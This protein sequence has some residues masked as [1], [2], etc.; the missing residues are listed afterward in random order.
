MTTC[1]GYGVIVWG[2][3]AV[4]VVGC[5]GAP[6]D[7]RQL[8]DDLGGYRVVATEVSNGC[9][10]GV[11]GSRPSFDFDIELSRESTELFWGREASGSLDAKLAFEF[12]A[13][14]RVPIAEPSATSKGCAIGRSDRITGTLRADTGGEVVGFSGRMSHAF[15]PVADTSCSLDDQIAAGLPRL[16]CEMAYELEAERTRAP[17]SEPE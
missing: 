3:L 4:G 1:S 8:G 17:S 15:E 16:P 5:S 13:L 6:A 7:G 10:A 12:R 2:A 11:L 14:V 9:G